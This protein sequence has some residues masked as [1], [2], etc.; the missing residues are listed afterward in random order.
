MTQE[1]IEA[2][3]VIEKIMRESIM[4]KILITGK[5]SYIGTSFKSWL[6]QWPSQYEVTEVDTRKNNWKNITFMNFDTV[7]HVAGIAH[8]K[9]TSKNR[10]LFYEVNRDLTIQIAKHAKLNGIKH[11]VFLS[12]MSV[13]GLE[14]GQITEKTLLNPKSAYGTSKYEAE[15]LLLE[16]EDEGF[17]VAIIRPPMVY[18]KNSSGNYK[19]LANFAKSSPVFPLVDNERSMIYIDNLNEYV[20]HIIDNTDN[21]VHWPQNEEYVNTS[22]MVKKIAEINGKKVILVKIFNFILVKLKLRVIQK[23]FGSLTYD[24]TLSSFQIKYQ[25]KYFEESIEFTEKRVNNK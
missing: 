4:K 7:F 24:K 17:K 11:F 1:L 12:T 10:Q 14:I 25:V 8:I 6:S 19:L 15:K 13:Y 2:S 23:V 20:R 22:L 18:G 16:L 21:G 3:T 9:E 5:H